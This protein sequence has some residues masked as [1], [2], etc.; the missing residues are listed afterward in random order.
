MATSDDRTERDRST[1]DA[2]WGIISNLIA[3]I[4]LYGFIGWL[5]S[6]WLGH[7]AL[8]M[9]GGVLVGVGLGLYLVHFRISQSSGEPPAKR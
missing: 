1:G 5:L 3:A 6:L 2:A 8:F 4:L 9:A 7:R